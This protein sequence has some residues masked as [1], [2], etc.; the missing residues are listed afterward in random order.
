MAQVRFSIGHNKASLEAA[1]KL[2]YSVWHAV[3]HEAGRESGTVDAW[4]AYG[5]PVSAA[6]AERVL[7]GRLGMS[8]E[9]KS[10]L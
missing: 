5:E 10:P 1:Q 9:I 2:P 6:A 4:V 8:C 7:R 3:F